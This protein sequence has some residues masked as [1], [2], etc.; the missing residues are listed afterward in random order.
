VRARVHAERPIWHGVLA[1]SLV[2]GLIV[3]ALGRL[4]GRLLRT[5][6]R[7]P[8]GGVRAP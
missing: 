1:A 2:V 7:A 3:F 6:R 8:E 5:A 4:L